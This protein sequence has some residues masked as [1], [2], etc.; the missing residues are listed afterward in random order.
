[1][2]TSIER[3]V[4]NLIATIKEDYYEYTL[5]NRDP[6]ELSEINKKM[7]KEFDENVSFVVGKKYIKVITGN[8]V[9]GFVVNTTDDLMFR[10][11]D[12]LRAASWKAPARNAARGNVF[13]NYE[14]QWTGPNYL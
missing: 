11:G 4:A 12:I 1:M 14:I 2:T 8:S 5:R 7:I 10:Y 9:W 13:E 6:S 3:A